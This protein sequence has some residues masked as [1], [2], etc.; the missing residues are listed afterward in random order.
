MNFTDVMQF[1]KFNFPGISIRLK[2]MPIRHLKLRANGAEYTITT[3]KYYSHKVWLVT[4]NN[5]PILC[6]NDEALKYLITDI[7]ERREMEK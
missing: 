7:I 2:L 6:E 3:E 4:R 1:I 5:L